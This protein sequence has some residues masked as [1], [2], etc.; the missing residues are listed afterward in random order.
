MILVQYLRN[1]MLNL[2]RMAIPKD[3]PEETQKSFE[4]FKIELSKKTIK[5][6]EK[7][8]DRTITVYNLYRQE[9]EVV[10]S[11]IIGIAHHID[12]CIR[13]ETNNS[14]SFFDIYQNLL[15]IAFQEKMLDYDEIINSQDCKQIR[16]ISKATNIIFENV[17][18]EK[19]CILEVLN[20]FQLKDYLQKHNF[21]Y[22]SF[23]QSWEYEINNNLLEK[24]I[25]IIQQKDPNCIIQTRSP[26]K[27][28]FGISAFASVSG[29]TYNYKEILKNNRYFYK[30]GKWYKKIRA[31]N[32]IDEKNN[33]E[34]MLPKGQ[35]IK[36]NIEY[37]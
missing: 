6:N 12:F 23:H 30:D 7:Y 18:D 34:N 31:C 26:N 5:K 28:I 4:W 11:L 29:Y 15:Y 35:G 19:T 17:M 14:K 10:N 32:Y 2:I 22:N 16:L 1:S 9:C 36:I 13:G 37:Q 3:V 33:L 24:S 27:I 21:K 20:S 25:K 8:E